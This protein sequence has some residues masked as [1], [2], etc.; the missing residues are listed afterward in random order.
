MGV[1]I[2]PMD[3]EI[4]HRIPSRNKQSCSL[5]IICKFTRLTAKEAVMQK[6]TNKKTREISDVDLEKCLPAES[7][8][9]MK[10]FEHLTPKQQDLLKR[11]K[12]FQKENNYQFC[13]VRNQKILL[14][15]CEENNLI[16]VASMEVLQR[17]ANQPIPEPSLLH[18]I[19]LEDNQPSWGRS[20]SGGMG[21]HRGEMATQPGRP[22][23]RSYKS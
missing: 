21:P 18:F 8:N 16:H 2:S 17:L 5:T 6:K 22:R 3:T 9:S 23:T 15:E 11:A 10:I 14:R 4:A 13:W 12:H 1:E 19:P 7:G 20:S